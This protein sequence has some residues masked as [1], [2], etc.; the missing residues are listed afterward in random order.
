MNQKCWGSGWCGTG[1]TW[2]S[3]HISPT[4]WHVNSRHRSFQTKFVFHV[5]A[6]W[7]TPVYQLTFFFQ[8]KTFFLSFSLFLCLSYL[9]STFLTPCQG[10]IALFI[11]FHIIFN[12]VRALVN[13]IH[14]VVGLLRWTKTLQMYKSL[15]RFTVCN[16]PV[17]RRSLTRVIII[18]STSYV[19][20]KS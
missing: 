16:S 10:T 5:S 17:A 14:Q 3:S 6:L 19:K 2:M 18:T 20:Q 8:E 4:K 15:T 11:F 7:K 1:A 9:N 13:L 12:I